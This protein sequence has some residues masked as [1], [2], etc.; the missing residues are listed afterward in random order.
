VDFLNI[1][2]NVAE[3]P[4]FLEADF[5]PMLNNGLKGTLSPLVKTTAHV[6]WTLKQTKH[7]Q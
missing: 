7:A 4:A 6:Q 2:E 5:S 1:D 3:T